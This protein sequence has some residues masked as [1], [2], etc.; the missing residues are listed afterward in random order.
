MR[1]MI[2]TLVVAFL[3]IVDFARY[4]GQNTG[5]VIDFV[6]YYAGKIVH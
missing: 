3:A 4:H 2:A 6:E 5:Q 1:L